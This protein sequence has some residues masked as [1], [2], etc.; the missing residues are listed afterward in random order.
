M[1]AVKQTNFKISAVYQRKESVSHLCPAS[2]QEIS[3]TQNSG[4]F[5]FVG[6]PLQYLTLHVTLGPLLVQPGGKGRAERI[7]RGRFMGEFWYHSPPGRT[8]SLSHAEQALNPLQTPCKQL[9][10]MNWSWYL[11]RNPLPPWSQW[12]KQHSCV[13]VCVC[14][15]VWRWW[16]AV[17]EGHQN[18]VWKICKRFEW[19]GNKWL[20]VMFRPPYGWPPYFLVFELF[21][22]SESCGKQI[23]IQMLLIHW[24]ANEFCLVAMQ[25]INAGW[26]DC[27]C[28]Y[29]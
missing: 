4:T 13:C 1:P 16:G 24:N 12:L 23:R 25:L 29:L 27:F 7:H 11:R 20:C 19:A 9:L 17:E 26:M 18:H 10:L 22:I 8:H 5:L 6:L 28:V 2:W 14:S 21:Y 15:L 3:C